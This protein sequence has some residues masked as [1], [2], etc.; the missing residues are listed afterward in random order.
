MK[1]N[2]NYATKGQITVFLGGTCN[3]S[4]WRE[5]LMPMLDRR[6]DAFNPVVDDWN[7]AAQAN[8]DR[9]KINDDFCL[10]VLTPE[11]AGLYSI[12]EVADDSNK[13]P[14]RT[15]CCFLKAHGGREF[16]AGTWRGIEKMKRDLVRNG[17][18]VC[19]DLE[20]VAAFLNQEA[21]AIQ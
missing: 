3:E 6:V 13:R 15:V 1:N 18:V 21:A 11:M 17:A 10:Y 16:D 8:E 2:E 4:T 5:E 19:E 20:G 7:E 14:D 9:H 12:F